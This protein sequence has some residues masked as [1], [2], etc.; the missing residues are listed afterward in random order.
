MVTAWVSLT[1]ATVDMGCLMVCPGSHKKGLAVHCATDDKPGIPQ[2]DLGEF[3]VPLETGTG[4]VILMNKLLQH[5]SLPNTSDRL[6]FSL[7][8]RYQPK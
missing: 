1:D 2:Q 7:D 3:K 6:R 8:L 5:G 4:D